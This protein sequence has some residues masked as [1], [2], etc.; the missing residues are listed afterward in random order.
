MIRSF[1]TDSGIKISLMAERMAMVRTIFFEFDRLLLDNIFTGVYLA[2]EATTSMSSYAIPA[3]SMWPKSLSGPTNCVAVTEVVNQPSKFVSSNPHYVVKDT[4]WIMWYVKHFC[5]ET[6][7]KRQ[8]SCSRYLLVKGNNE[9]DVPKASETKGKKSSEVVPFVK[10]DPHHRTTVGGKVIE[11]PDPSFKVESLL[12]ARKADY[13]REDPDAEDMAI[14]QLDPNKPQKASETN[15]YDLDDEDDYL[16]PVPSSSKAKAPMQRQKDDWKHDANYVTTTM[17][18]LMVPPFQ[19][20]PSASMAIQRELK[21]MIKEQDTAPSLRDLG[22]YMPPELIGDNLYQWI[23][24]MHSFDPALPIAKDLKAK[25]VSRS[26][27]SFSLL[28]WDLFHPG[29]STRLSSRS[30]FRRRSLTHRRSSGL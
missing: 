2:K 3:R 27:V 26:L 21:A 8:P 10:H 5:Y 4:H 23:V 17:E 13:V 16:M 28:I 6:Y 7:T 29:I 11:I 18:N 30:G 9:I 24:E 1:G 12:E 14:F 19:S 22:W 25:S 15:H 20:T